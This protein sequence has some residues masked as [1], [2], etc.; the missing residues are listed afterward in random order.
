MPRHL[1]VL[2]V[3]AALPSLPSPTTAQWVSPADFRG[4]ADSVFVPICGMSPAKDVFTVPA[5]Q[6][7]V[8]TDFSGVKPQGTLSIF[9]N[10]SVLRWQA[11]GTVPVSWKTGLVFESGH[12]FS[13]SADYCGGNVPFCWSGYIVP[14]G[15]SAVPLEDRGPR[16]GFRLSP[17]PAGQ[18]VTLR[19]ELDRPADVNLSIFDVQGHRV[20]T[21]ASGRMGAGV[22][23][24]KW[25]GR[26]R[27]GDPSASGIYF[28][29]LESSRAKSVHRFVRLR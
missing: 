24:K 27:S 28:A 20:S 21:V 14:G 4:G 17:N 6:V 15:M 23:V 8:L 29:R 16:L 18:V 3:L 22:Y 25:D 7:F 2:L 5:G 1:L 26:T 10:S 19:F 11:V 12:T 9:D 13:V